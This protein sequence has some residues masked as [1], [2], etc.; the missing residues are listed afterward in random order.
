MLGGLEA[1]VVE[2]ERLAADTTTPSD[3][4]E[5]LVRLQG[6]TAR[7]EAATTTLT[8]RFDTSDQWQADGARSA[9]GWL[10][11]QTRLP[12]AVT[13]RRVRLSRA[14]R[15]MPVTEGAWAAGEIDEAHVAVLA[16]ARSE[17]TEATFARDEK[18]LVDNARMLSF[19]HFTRT[20]AYW[21]QCADPDG[22][23][24][25][26]ADDREHR[27]VSLG[28]SWRGMWFGRTVLDPVGGAIVNGTLEGI[29]AELFAADWAEA[30]SRLGRE[31]G[32]FELART[33]PQRR[34]DALVQMAVRARTAPAGGRR[35]APLFSVFVGYETLAGR[36]CELANGTVITPGTLVPWLSVAD[37]E[38][39]VFASP[40][41]VIDIGATRRLFGGATRRAVE[42]AG[43]D[44]CYIPACDTPAE[45]CQADHIHPW[46][47]GG[48]TT[49]DNGRLACGHHNRQRNQPPRP[50]PAL[51]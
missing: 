6:L 46:A 36:V 4:G 21:V 15:H 24:D 12:R 31:P 27:Q 22:V 23:E 34:A 18:L 35:P 2:V 17:R 3:L 1:G 51:E 28:Q 32:H 16:G 9:A 49:V 25:A 40:S 10:A 30:R 39:A 33:P 29:E 45:R 19:E 7:L 8:G 5:I 37:I 38:R 47:A 14:L 50:P 41:R 13:R 43:R 48:P 20:V 11:W 44:G 26:A 42:L